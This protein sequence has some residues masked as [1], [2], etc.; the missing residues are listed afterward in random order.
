MELHSGRLASS[1]KKSEA[2][3]LTHQLDEGEHRIGAVLICFVNNG[4]REWQNELIKILHKI[5][6]I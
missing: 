1:R 6:K 5:H 2:Q 3:H 4:G